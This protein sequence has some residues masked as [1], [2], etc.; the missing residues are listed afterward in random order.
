MAWEKHYIEDSIWTFSV[1]CARQKRFNVTNT[2]ETWPKI[3][4]ITQDSSIE[5]STNDTDTHSPTST[6]G[7]SLGKDLTQNKDDNAGRILLI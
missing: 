2:P 4:A 1:S 7:S 5:K 3:S 6:T